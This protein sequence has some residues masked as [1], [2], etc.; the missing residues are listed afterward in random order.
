[1]VRLAGGALVAAGEPAGRVA[2]GDGA[3]QVDRDGVGGGAGVQGQADR[4]GQVVG[5]AGAQVT[6]QA[7]RAGHQ[8]GGAGQD[9]LPGRPDRPVL[10]G[11]V[12]P[13]VPL[14]LVV[15]VVP[16]V[17][18]QWREMAPPAG[19]FRPHMLIFGHGLGM[20]LGPTGCTTQ[21]SSQ[22]R[23]G[24]VEVGPIL[25]GPTSADQGWGH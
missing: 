1:V 4:G 11:P 25:V 21:G 19:E 5:Q 7:V 20:S 6:G 9:Q 17:W 23:E 14:L 12:P 18:I 15:P 10:P 22:Q 3:A 24:N 8:L 16:V 2:G 13:V